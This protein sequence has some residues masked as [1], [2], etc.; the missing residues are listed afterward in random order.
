MRRKIKRL[1]VR[2]FVSLLICSVLVMGLIIFGTGKPPAAAKAITDPFASIHEH[3]LPELLRYKARDGARLSYREYRAAG[4]QVAVLIHGSSG[5]SVD[6]H[7]LA[8]ALQKADISVLV[9]DLRGHGA[10]RPHGDIAY[11]GQLDDDL[12]DFIS[13]KKPDLPN[14][15]WT[16]LGFSSGGAFALRIA[17]AMP[18]GQA[19]DRYLLVSPYLRYNAPSVRQSESR[20]QPEASASAPTEPQSWAGAS[21]GRHSTSRSTFSGF[22][23]RLRRN[24]RCREVEDRVPLTASRCTCLHC[25]G[26]GTFGYGDPA[27]CDTRTCGVVQ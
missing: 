17:A 26:H 19:V 10:N 2:V 22:R 21:T 1:L 11:V 27:G 14:S 20:A 24:P 18:L 23:R 12:A 4:Q 13:R 15:V 9:P 25:F 7:P 8:L 6:M 3:A 16:I 5:S